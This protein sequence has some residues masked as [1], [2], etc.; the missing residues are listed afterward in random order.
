MGLNAARLT[1]L[2]HD[3]ASPLPENLPP[4]DIWIDRAV[5]HFLLEEAEIKGYFANLHAVVRPGGSAL[6]AE[7]PPT[8]A[9]RCAGLDLQRYSLEEITERLGGEFELVKHEDYTYI[10]P[11]GEPRPYIYA[12][13]RKNA[14]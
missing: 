2:H 4:A 14:G 8:G 13:Y 5:L 10:N 9:A 12:L 7:F 3:I 11:F 1:W 6:L